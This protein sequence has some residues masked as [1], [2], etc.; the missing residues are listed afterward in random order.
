MRASLITNVEINYGT[1]TSINK[2]K[3]HDATVKHTITPEIFNC[4]E[5]E[6]HRNNN[7]I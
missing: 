3:T 7:K 6:T 1:F 2:Y 4:D 5:T